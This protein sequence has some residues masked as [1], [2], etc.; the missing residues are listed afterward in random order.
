MKKGFLAWLR[1]WFFGHNIR[2]HQHFSSSS[3]RIVCDRCDGDW[4]MNDAA[5][6]V[7]P[8][9]GEFADFYKSQGHTIK[10]REIA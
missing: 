7:V 10:P 3:R 2:V 8:W 4:A 6:I 1:C 9:N 5:R